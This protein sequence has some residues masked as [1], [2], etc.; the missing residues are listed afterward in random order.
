MS[1]SD[2]GKAH[3][4]VTVRAATNFCKRDPA[5]AVAAHDMA[6]VCENHSYPHPKFEPATSWIL[7]HTI[8]PLAG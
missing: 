6:E 3:W 8:F 5:L 2:A 1:T 7:F 4:L